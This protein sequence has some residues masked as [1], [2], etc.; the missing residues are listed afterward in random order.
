MK[1]KIIILVV[2]LM[3]IPLGLLIRKN[4]YTKNTQQVFE[5]VFYTHYENYD[6]H[7]ATYKII[8]ENIRPLITEKAYNERRF[9]DDINKFAESFYYLKCDSS[10]KKLKTKVLEQNKD[11]ILLSFELDIALDY[12]DDLP[13]GLLT[14]TGELTVKKEAGEWRLD[15]YLIMENNFH[16]LYRQR[17]SEAK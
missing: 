14:F 6:D 5:R 9:D 2:I 7:W 16:E 13:Q 17:Q 8:R 11:N 15:S 1:K 3:L 12:I 10:F 4:I